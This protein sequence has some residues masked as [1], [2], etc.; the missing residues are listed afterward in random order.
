[1]KPPVTPPGMRWCERCNAFHP[2]PEVQRHLGVFARLLLEEPSADM[3]VQPIVD[4]LFATLPTEFILAILGRAAMR[5]SQKIA[6]ER[7]AKE[8]L[9]GA[10]GIA[11]QICDQLKAAGHS[12]ADLL[13]VISALGIAL[14]HNLGPTLAEETADW[15]EKL[16]QV[17][18]A[19]AAAS[20]SEEGKPAPETFMGMPL[21]PPMQG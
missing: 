10:A 1:M 15:R 17:A 4:A 20:D 2:A 21:G 3:A 13:T 9:Q 12:P 11:I 14:G 18:A 19:A 16:Q 5:L 8:G 6:G 7:P